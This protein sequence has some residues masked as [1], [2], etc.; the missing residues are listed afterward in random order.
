MRRYLIQMGMRVVFFVAAYFV[1]GWLRWSFVAFA[2][3]IPYVAVLLVNAG[4]DRVTYAT[5]AVR[6]TAP[7]E[8]TG[9]PEPAHLVVDPETDPDPDQQ[10]K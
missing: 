8:I 1:S 4:R 7:K 10:E 9:P 5:S 3:V 6:P 2:A